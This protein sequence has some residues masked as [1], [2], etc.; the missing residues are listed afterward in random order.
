IGARAGFGVLD[1]AAFRA[2]FAAF[3]IRDAIEEA[4]IAASPFRQ[5]LG[6]AV[7]QLPP[8]I[9]AL[10]DDPLERSASGTVTVARGTHPVARMMCR[11]L[12]FSPSAEDLP[13]AVAFEPR[14]SGEIW[15]R[16][17]PAGTFR[18]HLK[19]WPG[20]N[21]AMREC[22]G[23][24]A[25]GFRLETD[26]QGLRMVFERWWLCGIPLPRALGPRVAAVQWQ[27]GDDYCFSVDVAALGIGRVIAYRGRLR[28]NP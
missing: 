23:P 11:F 27:E 22:V 13:L 12:G 26:A 17:F 14:G 19:P 20:R 18:T 6:G 5:W 15:R 24:L 25:Y 9:R 28:L 16:I 7:D 21:G 4:P 8:A 3:K 10:H 2:A 1:L